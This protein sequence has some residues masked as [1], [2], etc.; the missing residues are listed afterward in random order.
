MNGDKGVKVLGAAIGSKAYC[1]NV[2]RKRAKKAEKVL[3]AIAEIEDT[4][5]GYHLAR[6]CASY[7]RLTYS[8]RTT[9]RADQEEA[10]LRYDSAQRESFARLHHLPL[11]NEVWARAQWATSVGGLGL[12]SAHGHAHAAYIASQIA[13]AALQLAI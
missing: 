6:V 13:T 8:T 3:Q 4:H 12:R 11:D 1:E 10:L 9:P 2:T 7:C 5:C